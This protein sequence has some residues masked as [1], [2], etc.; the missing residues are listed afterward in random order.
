M[1]YFEKR[2]KKRSD[3]AAITCI[4]LQNFLV[5]KPNVK[6]GGGTIPDGVVF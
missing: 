6:L 5:N 4:F 1:G 2:H 3:L